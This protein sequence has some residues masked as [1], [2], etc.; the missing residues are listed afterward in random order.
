[1]NARNRIAEELAEKLQVRS[2]DEVLNRLCVCVCCSSS[3]D[4][5]LDSFPENAGRRG[6]LTRIPTLP[7]ALHFRVRAA[8]GSQVAPGQSCLPD[9]VS[10]TYTWLSS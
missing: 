1:M 7:L 10:F 8:E 3:S 4:L 2:S 5:N 9:Q 6:D